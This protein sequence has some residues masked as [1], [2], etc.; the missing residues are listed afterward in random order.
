MKG[1]YIYS[2]VFV[3]DDRSSINIA[4]ILG[5]NDEEIGKYIKSNEK[6][7]IDLT[8]MYMCLFIIENGGLLT[9]KIK[10]WL[11]TINEFDFN[12]DKH[13]KKIKEIFNTIDDSDLLEEIYALDEDN[14]SIS[15]NSIHT[16]DLHYTPKQDSDTSERIEYIKDDLSKLLGMKL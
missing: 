15:Y 12:N 6:I 9:S 3:Y 7:M 13:I 10:E 16:S 1:T 8:E 5:H 11:Y 4:T 2:L 14:Q